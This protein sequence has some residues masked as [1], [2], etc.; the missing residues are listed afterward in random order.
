[1]KK[2]N[3]ADEMRN[4]LQT[5]FDPKHLEIVDDSEKH[6]GH[7][8]YQEGGQSHFSIEIKAGVFGP[9]NRI[10]R[11]RAVHSALGKELVTRIHALSLQISD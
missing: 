1:M 7:A 8:G 10:E 2:M 5:A 3:V 4:K 11:H 6:R 9:M